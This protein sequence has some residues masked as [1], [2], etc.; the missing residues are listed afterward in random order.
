MTARHWLRPRSFPLSEIAF[1]RAAHRADA[2]ADLDDSAEEEQAPPAAGPT[3]ENEGA[4]G[5]R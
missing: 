3:A 2:G 1:G 4:D 5:V